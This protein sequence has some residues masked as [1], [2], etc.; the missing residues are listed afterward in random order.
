MEQFQNKSQHEG[1]NTYKLK[2]SQRMNQIQYKVRH[3][4]IQVLNEATIKPPKEFSDTSTWIS[5]TKA[6]PIR[7]THDN[8]SAMD[9]QW[10][11]IKSMVGRHDCLIKKQRVSYYTRLDLFPPHKNP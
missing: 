7:P 4:R 11:S 6:F 3:P 2:P 1:W 10:S 5:K 9:T 8:T